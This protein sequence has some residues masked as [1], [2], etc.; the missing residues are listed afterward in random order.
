MLAA[1][2]KHE[3][4]VKFP[5]DLHP[6]GNPFVNALERRGLVSVHHDVTRARAPLPAPPAKDTI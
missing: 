6:G 2:A 4:G 5:M 3:E 1:A